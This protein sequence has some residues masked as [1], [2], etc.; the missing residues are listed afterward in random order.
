MSQS[1]PPPGQNPYSSPGMPSPQQPQQ[2][3]QSVPPGQPGQPGHAGQGGPP[4]PGPAPGT[5]LGGDISA[6]FSF[7]WDAFRR[8]PGT[9]IVPGIVYFLL[10]A[11]LIV[12]ASVVGGLALAAWASSAADAGSYGEPDP[13]GLIA[14]YL[15]FLGLILGAGLLSIPI[16]LLWSTGALR[17]GAEVVQGRRPAMRQA[18]AGT[19]RMILT[20]LLVQAIVMVGMLILYIPGIIASVALMFAVPAA[21]RGASP[22]EACRESL[23]LVRANL[24]TAIVATL[25][26]GAIASV[27]SM[28]IIT[29]VVSLPIAMLMQLGMYERL[30]GRHLPAV[31]ADGSGVR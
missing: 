9:L 11:V 30:S 6:A 25:L 14:A 10:I 23:A 8:N 26:I 17:A 7:S 1:A 3:W 18:F 27:G 12:V 28:L 2:Q 19:G 15:L 29:V 22:V 31:A 5:D 20:M 13:S 16:T 4:G 21:S 24:G